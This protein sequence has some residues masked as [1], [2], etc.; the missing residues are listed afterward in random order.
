MI[1]RILA[2]IT[3]AVMIFSLIAFPVSAE[4][5]TT[6]W[7]SVSVSDTGFSSSTLRANA[8]AAFTWQDK[9]YIVSYSGTD[10]Y[11]FDAATYALVDT[12]STGLTSFSPTY[13]YVDTQFSD[14]PLL[15]YAIGDTIYKWRFLY[16]SLDFVGS[17]GIVGPLL[18]EVPELVVDT[19]KSSIYYFQVMD[20]SGM[21]RFVSGTTLCDAKVENGIYTVYELK[22]STYF[23]SRSFCFNGN[24]VYT[25]YILPEPFIDGS[26]YYS[27]VKCFVYKWSTTNDVFEIITSFDVYDYYYK[28]CNKSAVLT[29]SVTLQ[30]DLSGVL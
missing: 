4:A 14:Y 11:L 9:G 7:G 18:P 23:K 25:L 2:L 19:N 13:F 5:V 6:S 3:A 15:Y 17:E 12:Y 26:Y 20:S 28:L 24:D 16:G 8:R 29:G 27:S 10:I 21:I 1:K 30:Y 22:T